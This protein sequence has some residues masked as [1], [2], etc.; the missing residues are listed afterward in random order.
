MTPSEH[1]DNVKVKGIHLHVPDARKVEIYRCAK[2]L[3]RKAAEEPTT[4]RDIV[5]Q[6][7]SNA[8]EAVKPILPPVEQMLLSVRRTRAKNLVPKNP[9]NL[10]ELVITNEFTKTIDGKQFLLYDSG[11]NDQRLIILSTEE[12]LKFIYIIYVHLIK[13]LH[14]IGT[15]NISGGLNGLIVPL[16]YA[17]ACNKKQE[18]YN[19]I[20]KTL[21]D[22]GICIKPKYV[23][24]DFEK[25]AINAV[26]YSF[27]ESQVHGCFFHFGQNVWRHIQSLGLQTQY[28]KCPVFAMNLKYLLALAFVPV[29]KVFEAFGLISEMDF[30]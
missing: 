29:E 11:P 25:A 27:P 12:N 21:L 4:S 19:F 17:L 22:Q 3:K 24:L 30:L 7:T 28:K 9:N 18:T 23:M 15:S 16:V 13:P 26:K 20:L 5:G 6:I 2:E 8:N 1:N 10:K 14:S